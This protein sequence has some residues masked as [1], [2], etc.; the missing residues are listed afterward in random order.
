MVR[1]SLEL[2]VLSSMGLVG[3]SVGGGAGTDTP[4]PLTAHVSRRYTFQGGLTVTCI[5]SVC[6][7]VD[8]QIQTALGLTPQVTTYVRSLHCRQK[9]CK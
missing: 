6:S 2:K 4:A 8:E 1:N 7:G 5:K 3:A 9:R